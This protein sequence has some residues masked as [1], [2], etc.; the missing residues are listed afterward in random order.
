[1][2]IKRLLKNILILLALAAIALLTW[3]IFTAPK[4]PVAVIRVTNAAGQPVEGATIRADGLRTKAGPYSSGHYGWPQGSNIPPNLDV[5]TGR[6][7]VA[8]LPYP[9]Y[10]FEQIET[11]QISF[12]V[13]HPDYVPDRPFRVVNTTPPAGAPLSEW[14][15]HLLSR[16]KSRALL[17]RT[18]PVVLQAG[19]ILILRGEVTPGSTL[20][21]QVSSVSTANTNFWSRPAADTLVS[22]QVSAGTKYVRLVRLEPGGRIFFSELATIEA[23]T[24]QTNE[25][26]LELRPGVQLRGQLDDSVPRPVKNGRVIAEIT[27]PKIARQ[28]SPPNWHAWTEIAEDG[29]FLLEHLP[30]GELEISAICDGFISTNGPGQFQMKYP[31][32][33]SIGT[34]DLEIVIGMEPTVR[35]EVTVRDESGRPFPG[36]KV[37]TW[38]NIRYGEWSATIFA[39]DCHNTADA[40]ASGSSGRRQ[41]QVNSISDFSGESDSNGV[42]VLPNLP[43]LVRSFSIEHAD[44]QLPIKD[45]GSGQKDRNASV[46]LIPGE[47]NRVTVHLEPRGK[48]LISHY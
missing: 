29:S 33:H 1:M 22:R 12:A 42:A 39:S 26:R 34:N 25:L 47:T 11:G 38:P 30:P 44:F 3:G 16:V 9:K 35:L 14:L 15:Q 36:A 23:V 8:H 18:D 46:K 7:G 10:V 40:F 45:D 48:S 2:I 17:A 27:P 43:D 20:H 28:D 5:R 13:S 31:Q 24:E 19:A 6:D 32:K 37:H 41:W 4:H 21:A